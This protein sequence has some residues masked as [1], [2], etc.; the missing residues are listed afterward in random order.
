MSGRDGAQ[1]RQSRTPISVRWHRGVE[2]GSATVLVLSAAVAPFSSWS[3]ARPWA[4]LLGVAMVFIG[5]V[6]VSRWRTDAAV[7]LVAAGPL[8]TALFGANPIH[9]WS[10]ACLAALYLTL[11]D[12]SPAMVAI[13]IGVANTLAAAYHSGMVLPTQDTTP[14]IAGAAA[15]MMAAIG[16]S[17]CASRKYFL[18]LGRSLEEAEAGREAAI[19][20]RIAEERVGIARDLHDSVGHE[21]AVVSMRLGAAEVHLPPEAAQAREDIAAARSGIQGVLRETQG[22]LRVLRGDEAGAETSPAPSYA[23]VGTLIEEFRRAGLVVSAEL[24]ALPGH[25]SHQVSAAAYRI[26][27]EALTNAQR[28]GTGSVSLEARVSGDALQLVVINIVRPP[29]A[30]DAD[31]ARHGLVG[32]R[33]RATEAGGTLTV[34]DNGSVFTVRATLPLRGNDTEETP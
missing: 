28:H 30:P 25:V 20:A 32:M 34:Q 27:Q 5:T 15:V 7:A 22:I 21:I 12:A 4:V 9:P 11:R 3:M 24:D 6:A 31:R 17:M 13:G 1:A 2:V 23:M 18:E 8:V 33:E 16:S 26:L 10:M 14:S 29:A 19:R